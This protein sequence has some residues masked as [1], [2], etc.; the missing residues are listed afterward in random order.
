MH[1]TGMYTHNHK[2]FTSVSNQFHFPNNP[3][4]DI[5]GFKDHVEILNWLYQVGIYFDVQT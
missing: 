5:P 4:V 3:E 2:N 1:L